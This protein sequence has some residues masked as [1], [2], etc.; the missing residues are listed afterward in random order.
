ME[1][2]H[3]GLRALVGNERSSVKNLEG[4]LQSNREKEFQASLSL[5]EKVTELQLVRD[6]LALCESK[7]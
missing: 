1:Q 6:R 7:M 2:E 5:Q 4:I 3:A